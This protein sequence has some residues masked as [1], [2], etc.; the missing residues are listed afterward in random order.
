[1]QL[2]PKG[3][4]DFPVPQIANASLAPAHASPSSESNRHYAHLNHIELW[5]LPEDLS[6]YSGLAMEAR[7]S[8]PN[9]DRSLVASVESDA[10]VAMR[11]Y[12]IGPVN[13]VFHDRFPSFRIECKSENSSTVIANI[14]GV[15][16]KVISRVDLCWQLTVSNVSYT[17]AVL[18]FKRPGSIQAHQW[19]VALNNQAIFGSARSICQQLCKYAHANNVHKVGVCDLNTMVLLNL[20]GNPANW[21]GVHDD[22]TFVRASYRWIVEKNEMKRHLFVFLVEAALE[23]LIRLGRTLE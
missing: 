21:L 12:I 17:F 15:D 6:K 20:H 14:R 9:E 4:L 18:E 3:L 22:G 11:H 13:T 5:Q 23:L 8:P 2:S 10:I 19:S 7:Y 16:R 1:L